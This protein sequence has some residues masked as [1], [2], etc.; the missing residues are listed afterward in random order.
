MLISTIPLWKQSEYAYPHAFGFIP[1]LTAYLHDEGPAD[2]RTAVMIIPGGGYAYPSFREGAPIARRFYAL[3][4]NCFVLT[5]TCNPTLLVP[6]GMQPLDDGARAVRCLRSHALAL[7]IHPDRIAVCGMSAGG[8]LAASL[9]VHHEEASMPA[10]ADRLFSA[11]P[12]AAIL[13]YPVISARPPLTHEG[14]VLALLGQDPP[15]AFLTFMSLQ[16]QVRE[17]TP[18]TFLWAT[19]TDET[20]PVG[21]SLVYLEALRSRQVPCEIHLYSNGGHGLSLGDEEWAFRRCR[22]T[23]TLDQVRRVL[24]AA[25]DGDLPLSDEDKDALFQRF[26]YGPYAG[27][28][29]PGEPVP[30]VHAWPDMAWSFLE[31]TFAGEEASC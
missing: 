21:N 25:E 22:E 5:Y 2:P 28:K 19:M 15:D 1:F 24:K 29:A 4:A 7:G 30:W 12:N 20:V 27:E 3:G 8:H 31:R 11:R 23:Y 6:L 17:D 16:E 26:L 10:P 14:S 18:P 13:S 9:C